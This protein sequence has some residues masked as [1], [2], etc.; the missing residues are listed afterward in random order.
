M[1]IT[2]VSLVELTDTTEEVWDETVNSLLTFN[3]R[4]L[5]HET[6]M[7]I[8]LRNWRFLERYLQTVERVMVISEYLLVW[9]FFHILM[10]S[11]LQIRNSNEFT[12]ERC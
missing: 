1:S 6:V 3:K 11:G 12:Q 8:R 10:L 2:L 7:F 4:G 9:N 5:S